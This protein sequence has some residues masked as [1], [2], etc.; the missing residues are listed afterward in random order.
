MKTETAKRRIEY[1]LPGY[2]GAEVWH[3][4][5]SEQRALCGAVVKSL[6]GATSQKPE[7]LCADC[8]RTEGRR[9]K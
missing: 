3:I 5:G 2:P 9:K 1:V 7:L 8:Q 6:Q 4:T